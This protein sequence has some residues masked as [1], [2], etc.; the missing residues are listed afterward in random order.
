M[1]SEQNIDGWVTATSLVHTQHVMQLR[2]IDWSKMASDLGFDADLI[3]RPGARISFDTLLAIYE[4]AADFTGDDA[5]GLTTGASVPIGAVGVFE[6]VGLSAPTL[7]TGLNNWVRFHSLP[8]NAYQLCF[9]EDKD[10]GYLHWSISDSYGP[11][12]RYVDWVFGLT[13]SRIRSMFHNMPVPMVAEIS[14]SP[15]ANTDEFKRLLGPNLHF[16]QLHDRLGVPQHLLDLELTD[17]QPRVSEPN[18]HALLLQAALQELEK[19]ENLSDHLMTISE[20]ITADLKN[21]DLSLENIALKMA[22][23]ARTLQRVLDNSGTSFR[24]LTETI[25][26]AIAKRYL[27]E[28]DIPLSEI[29]FLCGFSEQ[30]AFSRAAKTWL[31]VS[32]KEYRKTKASQI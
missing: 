26:M 10:Y 4:Y 25:R 5:I 27:T 22:M 32:P 21:G 2:G 24:R 15:P 18:L 14:H 17:L 31:G 6:Y 19:Q 12:A 16:N 13:S 30:S 7:R 11:R 20:Y 1:R 28:T 8:T 3:S 9:E 29:A 23:S